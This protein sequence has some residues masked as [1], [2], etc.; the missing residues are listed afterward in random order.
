MWNSTKDQSIILQT[1][2]HGLISKEKKKKNLI[3]FLDVVLIQILQTFMMKQFNWMVM[4]LPLIDIWDIFLA[5]IYNKYCLEKSIT[6][7]PKQKQKEIKHYPW[8]Q[9]IRI[10]IELK[11]VT[12]IWKL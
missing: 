12:P 4:L 7:Q 11:W 1:D 5:F 2:I 6:S 8:D 3:I 10:L 9:P